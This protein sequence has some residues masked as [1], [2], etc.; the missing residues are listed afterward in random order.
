MARKWLGGPSISQ[1][2][3]EDI[4]GLVT[5]TMPS[6]KATAITMLFMLFRSLRMMHLEKI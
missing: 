4:A 6:S 2:L 1:R 5:P 3:V